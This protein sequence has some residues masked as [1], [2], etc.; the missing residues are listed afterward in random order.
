[1]V[2]GKIVGDGE[3]VC[4]SKNEGVFVRVLEG[5]TT[6]IDDFAC[7]LKEIIKLMNDKP[8]LSEERYL[9]ILQKIK[10]KRE[11]GGK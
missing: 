10:E 1:V 4:F 9:E 11:K 6:E 5:K 8:I 2:I 7:V 3:L